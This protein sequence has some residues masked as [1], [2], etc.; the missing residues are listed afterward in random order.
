MYL[1]QL[2]LNVRSHS[3]VRD[4]NNPYELHRSIMRAFPAF[5]HEQ[6]RVLFRLEG[7]VLDKLLVQ[8][9]LEPDWGPLVEMNHYL[10]QPPAVKSFDDLNF[11][12]GQLLRF[13]LRANPVRRDPSSGKRVALFKESDRIAWLIRKG[14]ANGFS[15][16]QNLAFCLSSIWRRFNKSGAG[17]TKSITLNMV[18]FSG[19]LRVSDPAL[20]NAAMRKGIGPAKGL[21]CGLLALSPLSF[22]E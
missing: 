14:I 16:D 15:L 2:I 13:K 21:G 4:Q 5:E 12:P 19:V 8:S 11:I 3:V 17:K 6:E 20:L 22:K 10:D 7:D 1:S 9:T 18:D